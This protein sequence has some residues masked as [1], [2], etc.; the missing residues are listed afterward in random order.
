MGMMGWIEFFVEGLST[1]MNETVERG[2]KAMRADVLAKEY[3]LSERQALAIG[4]I[5]VH[6]RLVIQDYELICPDVNWRTLQR[7]LKGMVDKSL[8]SES[9][10]SPTDPTKQY[11]L[12]ERI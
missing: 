10:S 12:T 3:G 5:L 2:K 8:L 6:R 7:D 1:Q 9:G 4:H 11:Q